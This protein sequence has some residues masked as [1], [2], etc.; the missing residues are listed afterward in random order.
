MRTIDLFAGCG[1]LS[2]G[3]QNSGFEILRAYD[4]WDKAVECYSGNFDHEIYQQDLNDVNQLIDNLKHIQVDIIIGGPP[5]QDFSH[6]GKRS[7]GARA[8]L[9]QSFSE[10]ISSV[11][12]NWYVMENVDRAVK[13]QSYKSAR[14]KFKESGYGITEIVLDA[15]YCG[16]P[17]K[18]KRFFSIGKLD[19]RDGFLSE[20]IKL[21]QSTTP[22][23][24]RDYF[25]NSLG[26]EYYYRHPRNYNR[27]GVFSIDEP[28]PTMRGVNRPIPAGYPGHAGDP[29]DI[30]DGVRSLTYQERALIQTFPKNFKWVGSKTAIEQMIGNAVPVNLAA[31]VSRIIRDYQIEEWR[32]IEEG[33]LAVNF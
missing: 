14:K 25:G 32:L 15:S 22:M 19:E 8:G 28:A 20:R 4:N 11:R 21:S 31:F 29:V 9:T 26:F 18:R 33:S 7:E 1:G 2:L 12:P 23:S 17:Q 24:I 6:A 27:R 13:S 30:N 16:V 5:C 10:V 3:F